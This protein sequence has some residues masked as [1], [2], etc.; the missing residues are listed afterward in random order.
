MLRRVA[1]DRARRRHARVGFVVHGRRDPNVKD[2][3][4]DRF[5]VPL[6]TPE[7]W[8]RAGDARIFGCAAANESCVV[9]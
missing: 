2:G 4:A 6:A 3:D 7:I 9:T 5:F 1:P 8:L